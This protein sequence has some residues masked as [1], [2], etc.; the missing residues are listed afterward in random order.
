MNPPN[1][2]DS[3]A[4]ELRQPSG[5]KDVRATPQ[6]QPLPEFSQD[7]PSSVM[8]EIWGKPPTA[9]GDDDAYIGLAI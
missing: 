5:R 2:Q 3:D 1:P 4:T 9:R 8:L 6:G 7:A